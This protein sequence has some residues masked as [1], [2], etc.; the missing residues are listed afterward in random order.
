MASSAMTRTRVEPPRTFARPNYVSNISCPVRTQ[1]LQHRL[2]PMAA[3]GCCVTHLGNSQRHQSQLRHHVIRRISPEFPPRR[4]LDTKTSSKQLWEKFHE[5]RSLSTVSYR[6]YG[7]SGLLQKFCCT[8]DTISVAC[9][10]E[11]LAGIFLTV[12]PEPDFRQV[13]LSSWLQCAAG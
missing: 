7:R 8:S 12:R 2:P 9:A 6:L 10:Q 1:V 13:I 11:L 4:E 5:L 3:S